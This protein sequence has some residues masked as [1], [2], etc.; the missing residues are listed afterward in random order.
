M[1]PNKSF[2]R[3]STSTLVAEY[4]EACGDIAQLSDWTFQQLENGEAAPFL[5]DKGCRSM[6]CIGKV[7]MYSLP[8]CVCLGSNTDYFI[9]P[10]SYNLATAIA[11][12]YEFEIPRVEVLGAIQNRGL[13]TAPMQGDFL[14]SQNLLDAVDLYNNERAQRQLTSTAARG[15]HRWEWCPRF[16]QDIFNDDYAC[17]FW[18]NR[19]KHEGRYLTVHRAEVRG[20]VALRL[21]EDKVQLT[22]GSCIPYAEA[23]ALPHLWSLSA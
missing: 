20:N 18:E 17:V 7:I 15:G 14:L 16:T 12:T 19:Q 10:C 21:V 9:V 8:E 22:D 13:R 1:F 4:K 23:A 11:L 5:N 3:K 6:L 2:N